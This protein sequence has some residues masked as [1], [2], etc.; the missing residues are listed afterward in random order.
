VRQLIITAPNEEVDVGE[1]LLYL[2]QAPCMAIVEEIVD[3]ITV[4]AHGPVLGDV[5]LGEVGVGVWIDFWLEFDAGP[6]TTTRFLGHRMRVI[7][8]TPVMITL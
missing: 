6:T 1:E 2:L 7:L 8:E 3:A 4:D 5:V